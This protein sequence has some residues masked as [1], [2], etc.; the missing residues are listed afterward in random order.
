MPA[1]AA[2]EAITIGAAKIL[3]VD[4]R[5]GT[6]SVGKAPDFVLISGDPLSL[7]SDVE[8]VI[9]SGRIVFERKVTA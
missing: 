1:E 2:I 6:V 9:G 5:F 3:G 4:D 8:M 7:E